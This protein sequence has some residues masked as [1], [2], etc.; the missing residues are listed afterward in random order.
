MLA[1]CYASRCATSSPTS[2]RD[3]LRHL[4]RSRTTRSVNEFVAEINF[5]R[6]FAGF[7]GDREVI[8]GTGEQDHSSRRSFRPGPSAAGTRSSADLESAPEP[9][10]R[11]RRRAAAARDPARAAAQ[12]AREA[13]VPVEAERGF[14]GNY[15]RVAIVCP[16]LAR[17]IAT[18]PS[19]GPISRNP[20]SPLQERSATIAAGVREPRWVSAVS[21]RIAQGLRQRREL[22]ACPFLNRGQ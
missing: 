6:R 22:R 15:R 5:K 21:A 16:L 1:R 10:I 7:A 3:V 12:V 11:G 2:F 8:Q 13:K 9:A 14:I 18:A 4:R 17:W 20:W 19:L